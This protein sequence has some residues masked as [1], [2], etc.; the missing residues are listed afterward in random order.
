MNGF[1]FWSTKLEKKIY[2]EFWCNLDYYLNY[3]LHQGLWYN[4]FFCNARCVSLAS[5][6]SR[7]AFYWRME[8]HFRFLDCSKD[9]HLHLA[10]L[11]LGV[12]TQ[13]LLHY[14][15]RSRIVYSITSFLW[16]LFWAFKVS[17]RSFWSTFGASQNGGFRILK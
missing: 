11:T 14:F 3:L 6:L 17:D 2:T 12:L 7:S 8:D 4:F 10:K 1:E 9:G 13:I 5:T 15:V 16:N